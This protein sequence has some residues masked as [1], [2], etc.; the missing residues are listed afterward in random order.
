V[1]AGDVAGGSSWGI[2]SDGV[3]VAST[4]YGSEIIQFSGTGDAVTVAGPFKNAGG[5]AIDSTGFLYV[6]GQF[7]SNI[8]KVP[9]SS[10]GTYS[11]T[12]DPGASTFG[13]TPA[14]TVPACTGT[15][16]TDTAAGECLI[17]NPA[18]ALGYFGTESMAF[19]S[20]GD[21]F[22][23]T[24]DQNSANAYSIFEC[25]HSCLY[26]ASAAPAPVLIYQ[27]P[28]NTTNPTVAGQLYVGTM[29]F[30]PWGNLFFDDNAQTN[31]NGT[32]ASSYV[33]E[34]AYNAT[35]KTFATAPVTLAS[36]S[37]GTP[38]QYDDQI[39]TIYIDPVAGT[40]YFALANEG[41]FALPNTKTGGVNTAGL[42][43]VTSQG[44]KLMAADSTGNLYYVA[45]FS[46]S[47]VTGFPQ[48]TDA[49]GYISFGGPTFPGA[50]S[51]L[52][53]D[54]IVADNTANCTPTLTFTFASSEYTAAPTGCGGIGEVKQGSTATASTGSFNAVTVTFAPTGGATVAP[55]SGLTVGDGAATSA[56]LTAKGSVVSGI[57]QTTWLA[58]FAAGGVFGGPSQGS[59]GAVNSKGVIVIGNSYGGYIQE[60]TAGGTVVANVGGKFSNPAGVA[61][62]KNNYLFVGDEISYDGTLAS[63]TILKLPMISDPGQPDD[64]TYPPVPA[65]NALI[66]A[67]PACAGDGIAPDNAGICQI[68]LGGPNVYFGVTAMAIDAAGNLF[69]TTS[70]APLASGSTLTFE[71]YSVYECPLT[72]LYGAT[73][74][75]P[76]LIYAEP[77]ADAA[78]DQLY[79]GSIAVDSSDNVFFTDNLVAG[80]GSAYSYYS[81]LYE[82]KVSGSTYAAPTLLET[83]TPL[84]AVASAPCTY[85]NE[86][87]GV[88]TDAAG[89]LFF[90]DQYTGIYEL[91]NNSGSFNVDN[92]IAIASPGAKVIFPDG[93]GN[94]YFAG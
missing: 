93:K 58:P 73:P 86:L 67:L 18:A 22:I 85:N 49:L 32:E 78:G 23:G 81:D 84:C 39:D 77:A 57:D 41:I 45:S 80:T 14:T 94:F 44:A 7:T 63:N 55:S 11:W 89:D 76:I 53:A 25:T 75:N 66:E 5:I 62:D 87:D 83:L 54:L 16:K 29:A 68:T 70:G 17:G 12:V 71:G 38:S 27:E 35:A 82:A 42:Y 28:I 92:P 8:I 19:D 56:P 50:T 13:T 36:F 4:T 3:I 69:Y 10:T 26:T 59:S 64:G 24:D 40:V 88:S 9:M 65:T 6:G 52:T 74:T 15:A 34:L 51:A 37:D 2:N 46:K 30:D 90:A 21:L 43:A 31:T 1:L 47:G 61:I 48:Y 91:V 33:K 20:K 60:F 72:C 79:L